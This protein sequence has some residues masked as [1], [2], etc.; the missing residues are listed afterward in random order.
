MMDKKIDTEKYLHEVEEGPYYKK[1]SPERSSIAGEGTKGDKLIVEGRVTDISGNPVPGAW[2]DF[3]HADGT[4]IYDN[5][6]YNL[7]GHQ[8]AGENGNFRLETVKPALYGTRAPH[9]HL[10][11]Q[12]NPRSRLYTTQLFFPEPEVNAKDPIFEP[13]NVMELTETPEGL[14]AR[15]DIIIQTV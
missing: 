1:N 8:Y 10:K 13:A 5:D 7:R 3:W 6:G 2:L 15:F 9:I 12:A 4:G 11:V 14:K